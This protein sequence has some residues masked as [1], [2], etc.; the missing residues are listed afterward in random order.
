MPAYYLIDEHFFYLIFSA[1]ANIF[2]MK[3]PYPLVGS[4]TNTWVTA[5]ISLSFWIIGEPDTSD[6]NM[7][8]KVLF[9]LGKFSNSICFVDKITYIDDEMS[10]FVNRF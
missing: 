1:S 5:P 4:F 9:F 3:I 2:L 10:K 8:Q 6:V 7:G